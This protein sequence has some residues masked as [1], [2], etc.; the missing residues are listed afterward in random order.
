[1]IWLVTDTRYLRQRMPS[2][3]VRWL[4]E[5]EGPLRLV[6]ADRNRGEVVNEPGGIASP[7]D[8]RW[9]GL[10]RG[11]LVVARSRDPRALQLLEW[12]E[13]A[14]ARPLDGAGAIER[15]RDKARCAA[16]LERRGVPVPPTFLVRQPADLEHAASGAF[17][18][19]LKPVLGDNARGLRL[20][21][22]PGELAELE[23]PEELVFAQSFLDAGGVDLK[24][25][26][27][28]EEIWAIRRASPLTNGT[29]TAEPAEVTDGVR[30]LVDQCRDEFGLTLFGLDVLE[31]ADGSFAVVDVN[32]FPNYTGVHEAPA[33]IGRL[34]LERAAR[35][36]REPM[37]AR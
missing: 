33:A 11:D 20:V 35:Q 14:G 25:Y 27:A 21:R 13:T 4:R 18:L 24:V 30:K 2:A 10:D 34:V 1:M 28:G 22:H 17:P 23:W 9:P 29:D 31:L 6:V 37:G 36:P 15:V 16:A 8:P 7:G 5:E 26:V 19:L 32:E 3:L 12:A